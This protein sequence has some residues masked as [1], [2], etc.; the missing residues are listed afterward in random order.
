M[1][2]SLN[3]FVCLLKTEA[4]HMIKHKGMHDETVIA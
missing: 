3:D 1:P 2:A 4:T